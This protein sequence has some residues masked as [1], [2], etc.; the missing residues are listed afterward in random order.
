MKLAEARSIFIEKSKNGFA[1]NT[2]K[3]RWAVWRK[4]EAF[5]KQKG[6]DNIEEIGLNMQPFSEWLEAKG[7][8]GRTVAQNI[9][10]TKILLRELGFQVDY[11]YRIDRDEIQANKLK[12]AER[13]FVEEDIER[14]KEWVLSFN[15]LQGATNAAL[16]FFLIETGARVGELANLRVRDLD[17]D[18]CV[19]SISRSK[20]RPR[21]VMFS[22]KTAGLLTYTKG[23]DNSYYVFPDKEE[24]IRKSVNGILE[25]LGLKKNGDGRGP[26]TFRHWFATNMLFNGMKPEHLAYVMGDKVNV[27]LETYIHPTPKMLKSVYPDG[28]FEGKI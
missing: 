6:L 10:V 2:K 21:P 4:I 28:F 23:M 18:A 15:G 20:T 24:N 8:S 17:L 9:T 27:V 13:M 1:L 3:Q 14:L 22:R 25:S 5:C 7:L 12:Q 16:I 11:S 19:A 26:H